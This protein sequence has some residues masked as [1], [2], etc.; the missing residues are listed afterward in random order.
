MA[1]LYTFGNVE[2]KA[3]VASEFCDE[4]ND[5]FIY[6][7]TVNSL[8]KDLLWISVVLIPA[9]YEKKSFEEVEKS[10]QIKLKEWISDCCP[11]LVPDGLKVTKEELRMKLAGPFK[12]LFNSV[13]HRFQFHDDK[14]LD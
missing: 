3:K 10:V 6:T 9:F 11:K 2:E 13:A 12:F 1:L 5:G 7:T 4:N 14:F 8:L